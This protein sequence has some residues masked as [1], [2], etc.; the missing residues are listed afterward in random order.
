MERW[1][2][3]IL[4]VSVLVA[5]IGAVSVWLYLSQ[6]NLNN[7]YARNSI[8]GLIN[9][10]AKQEGHYPR[11]MQSLASAMEREYPES[12]LGPMRRRGKLTIL[13]EDE[14]VYRVRVTMGGPRPMDITLNID[15][16]Q[17]VKFEPPVPGD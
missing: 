2:K 16:E 3:V 8:D 14:K 13:H 9:A 6:Q 17:P 1:S 12:I 10:Y 4:I 11:D 5:L 15:K 7:I